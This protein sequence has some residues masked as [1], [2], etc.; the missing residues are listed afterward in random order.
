MQTIK[1]RRTEYKGIVY[2]SKSEAMF[3][4]YLELVAQEDTDR[5]VIYEPKGFDVDGWRPDFLQWDVFT[6]SLQGH[7]IPHISYRLIEY[8]PSK[9]TTTYIK[10]FQK[11]CESILR[12]LDDKGLFDFSR[13]CDYYIFF[14][15]V[16]NEDRG[17]L[18]FEPGLGVE[19]VESNE[20]WLAPY[21]DAVQSTRFDLE[22][23][24]GI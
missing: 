8:K 1:A 14:G 22:V 24:V 10:E 11:R 17:S 9:P 2:R 19:P 15:S 5:G 4:R 7:E 13:R 20:D 21:I 18:W 6:G 23:P 12:R 16:F 3:A